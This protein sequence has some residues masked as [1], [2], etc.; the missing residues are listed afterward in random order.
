MKNFILF[1][2]V[3]ILY[4]SCA[5]REPVRK[6]EEKKKDETESIAEVFEPLSM[7]KDDVVIPPPE[8]EIKK[9]DYDALLPP[10][11]KIIDTSRIFIDEVV[12]GWRVQVGFF[13]VVDNAIEVSDKANGLLEEEIY[14]DF[15]APYHK[16]RVG[17]CISRKN[18]MALLEKVKKLGFSDAFIIPT[19]VYKYPEL[20]RQKEEESRGVEQ[21]TLNVEPQMKK[22]LYR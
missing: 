7:L 1:L 12:Q 6:E 14:L 4:L 3:I 5:T 19:I 8:W 15:D 2:S 16:I 17:D 22:D 20:R 9:I 10:E 11:L 18:A 13:K 21:D